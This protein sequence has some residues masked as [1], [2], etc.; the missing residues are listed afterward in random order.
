MADEG[1]PVRA[2]ARA[3]GTPSNDVYFILRDALAAGTIVEMPRDDWPVG[4]A[5]SARVVFNGTILEK[6]EDLKIACARFFKASPL[7]AAML[8]L[9]L[10]R[11]HVTKNQLHSVIETNRANGQGKEAT[12]PKMVDV[13]ICKLRKKIKPHDIFIETM[14]GMGYTI[15]KQCREHAVQVLL[16]SVA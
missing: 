7:E 16:R 11:D 12:D 1:I 10:R 5:R 6:D 2:I 3:I 9:M 15:S 4:T 14:W 8:T 13:L